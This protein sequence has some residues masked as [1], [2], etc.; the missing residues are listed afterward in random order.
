MSKAVPKS[1][2]AEA[3]IFES[4]CQ[5]AEPSQRSD[6]GLRKMPITVL[7][8]TGKPVYHWYFDWIVHDMEGMVSKDR[9]AFDYR[10][11]PDEP[12]GYADKITATTDLQLSG[13][14]LSRSSDDEAAKIM[15]LGPAGVPYEA[16]IHFHP[17]SMEL[18]FLPTGMSTVV[19][20]ETIVGPMTIVRKWELLRCAIC[21]TGV[22]S[23]S[24]TSFEGKSASATQFELTW[25]NG[26]TKDNSKGTEGDAG[27]QSADTVSKETGADTTAL[28]SQFEAEMK[29]Q[30]Q[31]YIT[32][33]G[34]EDGAK[35]FTEGVQWEAALEAHC[36]KLEA[37]TKA[38]IA[39]TEATKTKL[40]QMNLGESEGVDTGTP[41]GKGGAKTSFEAM[42]KYAGAKKE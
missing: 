23:G 2:P 42:H 31:R 21:L 35:Y 37:A 22:D 19:N 11:D 40:S 8:R 30:L 41:G 3:F 36:A 4:E 29:T 15:D 26:M 39:E 32:K 5:F 1:A 14:L 24:Q 25:R 16:S 28:R 18:E 38:A 13:E 27:K 9:I 10:H 6:K 7:A 17:S 12:I 20:G 33:F 34:A